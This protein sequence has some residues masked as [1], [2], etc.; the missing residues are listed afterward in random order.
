MSFLYI[1][2]DHLNQPCSRPVNANILKQGHLSYMA[3]IY[4]KIL[5]GK[6]S[7]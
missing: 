5:A 4:M 2:Y 3:G 7:L 6:K 1:Q